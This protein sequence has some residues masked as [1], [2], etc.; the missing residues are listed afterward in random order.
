MK[1]PQRRDPDF[2]LILAILLLLSMGL[3][4]VFSASYVIAGESRGDPYYFLRRQ[5]LWVGLGLA[6]MFILSRFPYWR[7]RRLSLFVLLANFVLLTL[8]FTPWERI[9]GPT[10]GAG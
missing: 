4:M 8:V 3:I 5:A 7:Y 1:K 9:W 10:P 6:G 2:A